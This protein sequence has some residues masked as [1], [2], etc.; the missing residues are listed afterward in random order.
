[1][2]AT[3]E[4]TSERFKFIVHKVKG[5]IKMGRISNGKMVPEVPFNEDGMG[6]AE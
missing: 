6:R 2:A 1:M 3:V 5:I 4:L